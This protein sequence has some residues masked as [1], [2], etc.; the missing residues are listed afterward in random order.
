[1]TFRRLVQR[2]DQTDGIVY[3]QSGA[4]SISAVAGCLLLGVTEVGHARYLRIHVTP[5]VTRREERI[6]VIG[7]EL[8][9]ANE[10]LSRSWV[11]NTAD[12]YALFIRI[13]SGGSI[14]SFETEEAQRIEGA[15]GQ[16]LAARATRDR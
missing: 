16:E 7:H 10:I 9:H 3:I 13:G 11:R 5:H 14:R 8:Q 4:C 15:I 2:I 6:A 12:A 1:V